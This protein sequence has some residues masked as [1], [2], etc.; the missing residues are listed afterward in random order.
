MMRARSGLTVWELILFT[1]FL[2]IAGG[3]SVFFFFVNS[4]DVRK[5]QQKYEWVHN[6]NEMLD[7]MANAAKGSENL[8][9]S[10]NSFKILSTCH[11]IPERVDEPFSIPF[12]LPAKLK[13]WQSFTETNRS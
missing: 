9:N 11:N 13:S 7:T 10:I 3:S 8:S 4:S 5:A 12:L 1:I 6:T 2:A